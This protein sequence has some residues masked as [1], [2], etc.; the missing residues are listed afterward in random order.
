VVLARKGM[1]ATAMGTE[2]AKNLTNCQTQQEHKK[3]QGNK[4]EQTHLKHHGQVSIRN[5]SSSWNAIHIKKIAFDDILT[6]SF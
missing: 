4:Q 1:L 6:V 2:T 5:A 3:W